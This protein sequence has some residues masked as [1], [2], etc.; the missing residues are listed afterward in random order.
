MKGET[1]F[2]HLTS[3][4]TVLDRVV[5]HRPD[6]AQAMKDVETALWS[7]NVIEPELLAICRL[8][9]QQLLDSSNQTQPALPVTTLD[10]NRIEAL[11]EWP[12]S[13][14]FDERQRAVLGFA[15]QLL[16]DAQGVTD[17]QAAHLTEIVGESGFLVL[18]Y[19]C[20]F[21]ETT[22][23]AELLLARREP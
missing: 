14:L 8:R 19:A 13:P 5:N 21:F 15:E 23:R 20:G 9:V 18:A 6:Y 1:W 16:V 10:K 3:G 22:Q 11:A 7:Q 12:V 2:P 17:E 4:D